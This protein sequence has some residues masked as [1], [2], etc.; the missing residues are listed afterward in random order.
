[1]TNEKIK[2]LGDGSEGNPYTSP[3]GTAGINTAL[4]NLTHGGCL[5]LESARYNLDKTVTIET[6]SQ[7]I[8]G[9]VWACN[10]DPN[11]VFESPNGTKL[12]LTGKDFPAKGV[13]QRGVIAFREEFSAG[14]CHTLVITGGGGV[15]LVGRQE[16][17]IALLGDIVAVTVRAAI[18]SLFPGQRQAADGAAE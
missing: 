9:K 2:I 4:E 17:G 13:Q 8:L 14:G 16:I 11:G 1:M 15:F 12:R 5:E 7:K 6:S 3:D 18:G 10:T